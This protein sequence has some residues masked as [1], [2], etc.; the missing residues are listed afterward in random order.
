MIFMINIINLAQYFQHVSCGTVC[1]VL[2]LESEDPWF[3]FQVKFFKELFFRY[4]N[5]R[6]FSSD[7]SPLIIHVQGPHLPPLCPYNMYMQSSLCLPACQL[8]ISQGL[9]L[10]LTSPLT[11]ILQS[12]HAYIF[13]P[14]WMKAQLCKL[15]TWYWSIIDKNCL[16]D[17]EI[18]Y[19]RVSVYNISIK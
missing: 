19:L 10:T 2:D 7:A 9:S 3:N 8:Y 4:I 1:R 16:V 18:I 13:S 6:N 17:F 11:S 15:I 5:I 12:T 14:Y